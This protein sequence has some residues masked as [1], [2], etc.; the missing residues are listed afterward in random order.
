[1]QICSS[2]PPLLKVIFMPENSEAGYFSPFFFP[3]MAKPRFFFCQD[4]T[5]YL[6]AILKYN[7]NDTNIMHPS[8]CLIKIPY[9]SASSYG[10]F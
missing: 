6:D 5:F 4:Y 10:F 7:S 1:M 2:E 3:S 9:V 8:Y